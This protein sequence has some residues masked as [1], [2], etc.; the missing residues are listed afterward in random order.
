MEGRLVWA[1]V[2]VWSIVTSS[3]ACYYP[4]AG[5]THIKCTKSTES[6]PSSHKYRPPLLPDRHDMFVSALV[7]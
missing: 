3:V 7:Q 2:P 4:A 5:F 6:M 1:C